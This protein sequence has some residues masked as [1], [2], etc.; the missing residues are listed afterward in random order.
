MKMITP[1][2]L[3]LTCCTAVAVNSV[4]VN[5]V[6]VNSVAVNSVAVNSVAVNSVD[7]ITVDIDQLGELELEFAQVASIEHYPGR[8]L[9]ATATYRPGEV[10]SLVTPYRM[11][12]VV[13]LVNPG[14]RVVAQQPLAVLH[15]PEIHHFLTEFEVLEQRLAAARKRYQANLALYQ[16]Q[17]I[18]EAGWIEIS[19]TYFSLRLEYEHLHHFRRLLLP[20]EEDVEPDSVSLLAPAG[21]TLHYLLSKPGIEAGDELAQIIPDGVLRLKVAAPLA[22]RESLEYLQL[23]DCRLQVEAVSRI[24]RDYYVE[25]WTTPLDDGCGALPGQRLR[26]TPFYRFSGYSVPREAV[27]RG[28]RGASVLVREGD[29]LRPVE[30]EVM[31]SSGSQYSV[32]CGL[33]IAGKPVLTRS[34]AAVQGVIMG[35]GGE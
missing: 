11:Q 32:A 23:G 26:A 24:A 19:D 28:V 22:D 16:R 4:A 14:E 9:G 21:G 3:A 15:G 13:Y 25:A 17:A 33:Q 5:A 27:F 20:S 29:A 18:G 1:S 31:G 7:A 8:E 12:R 2:V 30:V 10:L 34:V 6:A 35:L